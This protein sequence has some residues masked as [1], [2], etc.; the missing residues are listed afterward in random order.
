MHPLS[1]AI[2]TNR[3]GDMNMCHRAWTLAV[4]LFLI[5]SGCAKPP[6][7]NPF[8]LPQNE[9]YTRI[10]VIGMTPL[11]IPK[12]AGKADPVKVKM[13]A[14]MTG[15]LQEAGFAV[16][17][18]L[19][20]EKIWNRLLDQMGGYFDPFTGKLEKK[21]YETMRDYARREMVA[22]FKIEGLLYP[23]IQSVGAPINGATAT[24]DGTSESIL[25]GDW[26]GTFTGSILA[27]SLLI[28]IEDNNGVA[29]YTNRGGIQLLQKIYYG[30][31][32]TVST[33]KLLTD[34]ERIAEA[35]HISLGPFVSHSP[36]K[37][38]MSDKAK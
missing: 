26:Y 19:E 12:W 6:A 16:I 13:E 5:T 17:A 14:Q 22:K 24:W 3:D 31:T 15:R 35:I 4:T 20:Y 1:K 33:S 23:N 9:I 25:V 8:Q 18:P 32:F 27:M 28:N 38:T 30:K 7:Y 21:K 29:L 10:K 34:E 37:K 36:L 2:S 11:V